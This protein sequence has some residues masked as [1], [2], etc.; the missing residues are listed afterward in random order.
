MDLR[1]FSPRTLALLDTAAGDRLLPFVHAAY[2]EEL[3]VDVQ[4]LRAGPA[5]ELLVHA[6]VGDRI[7]R[8]AKWPIEQVSRLPQH[9]GA[10][11]LIVHVDG[12][13]AQ[14]ARFRAKHGF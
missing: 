11:V 13:L 3:E 6:L 2:A 10:A 14:A 1:T 9:I 8:E 4:L 7:V 5:F 12:I